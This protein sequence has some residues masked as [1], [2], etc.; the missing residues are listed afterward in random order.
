MYSLLVDTLE[1]C[2]CSALAAAVAATV[3]A[4]KLEAIAL[5][6][7]AGADRDLLMLLL[8]SPARADCIQV[9]QQKFPSTYEWRLH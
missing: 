7:A 1:H 4:W 8:T 9:I 5:S 2:R 6:V 3:A